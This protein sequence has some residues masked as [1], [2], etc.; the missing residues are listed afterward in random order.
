MPSE[1]G[2]KA[3]VTD[4]AHLRA[5]LLGAGGIRRFRGLLRDRRLDRDGAPLSREQVLRVRRWI[6]EQGA[7]RAEIAW[8]G[9]AGVSPDGMKQREESELEVEDGAAAERLFE[10]LGYREAQA[11]DRYV[12]VYH[13]GRTVVRLEWYPR[14]DVLVEIGGDVAGIEE[15]IRTLR[16]PREQCLPEALPSFAL[17][18]EKRTG[19]PAILAEAEL[20]GE[21][22]TWS[23]A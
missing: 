20:A 13:L 12:E 2:L 22:P 19:R 8:K 16:L 4:P 11:I 5:A 9:P 3:V 17:R 23:D 6:P 10:A 7:E 18:F 15:V 21:P 14:M 1:L